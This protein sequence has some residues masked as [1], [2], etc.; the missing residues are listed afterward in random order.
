MVP[1]LTTAPPPESRTPELLP[2]VMRPPAALV[3]LPLAW[4]V[5]T[6]TLLPL[7]D[8]VFV[9]VRLPVPAP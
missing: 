7:I 1:S 9:T 8:P 3:T 2:P 4:V 6:P 5:K